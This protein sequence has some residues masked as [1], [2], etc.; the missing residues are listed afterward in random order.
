MAPSRG[1]PALKRERITDG[2]RHD[3]KPR[4]SRDFKCRQS[5]P[6]QTSYRADGSPAL[7]KA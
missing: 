1:P 3:F 7:S 6:S 2:L 4:P 5:C